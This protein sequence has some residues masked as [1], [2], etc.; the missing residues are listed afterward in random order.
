VNATALLDTLR[1]R[2]IELTSDGDEL[3]YR[4][5]KGALTPELRQAIGERR[6]E[7]LALVRCHIQ[8]ERPSAA[9][10]A[11]LLSLGYRLSWPTL[12]ISPFETVLPGEHAWRA[13]AHFWTATQIR[14]ALV[15]ARALVAEPGCAMRE[16][17]PF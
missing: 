6:P 14:C 17:L 11:D 13:S 5:P 2:G 9:D 1:T 12:R 10:V 7:L 8:L 3:R 15:A 16:E 4:A